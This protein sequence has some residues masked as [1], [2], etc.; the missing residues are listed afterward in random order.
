[1]VEYATDAKAESRV[2]CAPKTERQLEQC[3]KATK[4][5]RP[6]RERGRNLLRLYDT[7]LYSYYRQT[8]GT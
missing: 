8:G 7:E 1:M 2:H 3:Q 5:V 4:E 6:Q